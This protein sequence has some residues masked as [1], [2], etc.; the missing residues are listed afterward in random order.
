M[1]LSKG[2]L[3]ASVDGMETVLHRKDLYILKCVFDKE[4]EEIMHP[5]VGD[6]VYFEHGDEYYCM[7]LKALDK[8]IDG[9][10]EHKGVAIKFGA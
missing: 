2:W 9:M 5:R 1:S 4:G 7:S 10:M 6:E 8:I 3:I